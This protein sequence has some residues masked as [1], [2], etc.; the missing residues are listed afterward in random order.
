M[1]FSDK[2]SIEKLHAFALNGSTVY[3]IQPERAN[4]IYEKSS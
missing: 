3:G 1:I 2:K 4:E